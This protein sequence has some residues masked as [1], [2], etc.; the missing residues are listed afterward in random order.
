MINIGARGL[1]VVKWTGTAAGIFGGA[2]VALNLGIVQ[3]GFV[4]FLISS[5][6]WCL[7]GLI[8]REPSL[9][10]LQ[11]VFMIVDILGVWRWAGL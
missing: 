11:A 2:I 10:I 3:Y 4:L 1:S 9:Y 7:A 6:L 5:L 8:Q